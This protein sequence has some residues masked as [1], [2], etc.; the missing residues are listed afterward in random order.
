[1]PKWSGYVKTFNVKEG[2]NKLISFCIDDKK[3]L[4]KL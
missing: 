3:L 4:G 2:N 1:M